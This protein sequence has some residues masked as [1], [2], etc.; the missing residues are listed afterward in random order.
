VFPFRSWNGADSRIVTYDSRVPR[1]VEYPEVVAEAD[2]LGLRSL[3]PNSGAFGFP[4]A[5]GAQHAG[6]I[7]G[8]DPSLRPAARELAVLVPPPVEATLSRLAVQTWGELLP[9]ELWLMPK[10]HWAYELDFGSAAWMP[11]LLQSNGIAPDE[12]I[13]RHDGTAVAF[14]SLEE[15]AFAAIAEGLLTHLLGSDFQLMFPT[16]PVVCTLHH[17]KQIWWSSPDAGLIAK[18]K[19]L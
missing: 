9:G 7:G 1:I 3:Y 15:N 11:Q 19:S 5:V 4:P 10:A 16:K 14:T 13:H 17:H 2:R 12:L 8:E 18:L 6:W